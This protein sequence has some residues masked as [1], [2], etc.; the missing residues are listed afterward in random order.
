MLFSGAPRGC[1][2]GQL[3]LPKSLEG[4]AR[5]GR[6]TT[7]TPSPMDG[8]QGRIRQ[9]GRK[10]RA[11]VSLRLCGPSNSGP[12]PGIHTAGP[13]RFPCGGPTI[14]FYAAGPGRGFVQWVLVRLSCPWPWPGP[15]SAGADRALSRRAPTEPSVDGHR[16][17][18]QSTG[19]D[20]ALSRRTPT[21]SSIDGHR[22]GPK[23][24]CPDRAPSRRAPG[25]LSCT[26]PGWNF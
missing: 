22:P 6:P 3:T 7:L 15:Q 24:A 5:V 14:G 18:P 8:R 11:T 13:I 9:E 4:P 19:T 20:R 17:G 26:G 16:P 12:W 21:V 25:D 10:M 1:Q 23:S 2:R